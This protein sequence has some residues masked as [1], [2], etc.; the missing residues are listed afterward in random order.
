MNFVTLLQNGEFIGVKDLKESLCRIV[1]EEKNP[2]FITE[3]GTP[4][5]VMLP[6]QDLLEIIDLIEELR[7]EKLIQEIARARKNYRKSGGVPLS[8]LGKKMGLET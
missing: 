1:R 2:I 3:R 5:K 7:D 8:R 4:V 6:Y